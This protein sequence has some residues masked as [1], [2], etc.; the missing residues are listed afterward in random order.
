MNFAQSP[1]YRKGHGVSQSDSLRHRRRIR[2]LLLRNSRVRVT[3]IPRCELCLTPPFLT[4]LTRPQAP[5]LPPGECEDAVGP[6]VAARMTSTP[7]RQ[8]ADLSAAMLMD[9]EEDD[10]CIWLGTHN[11]MVPSEGEQHNQQFMSFMPTWNSNAFAHSC[12]MLPNSICV[13]ALGE[14]RQ[15]AQSET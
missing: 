7:S 6:T 2:Y 9:S 5:T 8:E 1:D 13:P 3:N 14:I 10:E 15:S 12:V 4:R 11:P